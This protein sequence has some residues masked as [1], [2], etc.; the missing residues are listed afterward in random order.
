MVAE[1][2]GKFIGGRNGKEDMGQL[3]AGAIGS[4]GPQ[5]RKAGPM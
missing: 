3:R 4:S 1:V 2:I 5:R